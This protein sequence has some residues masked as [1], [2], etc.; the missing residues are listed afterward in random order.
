MANI[1]VIIPV[2]GCR[3]CLTE[4][5][6]RLTLV[7]SAIS[8]GYEIIFV[9]DGSE[10]N[11][12]EMIERLGKK[13]KSIKGIKL[14]RNFGQHQAISAGVDRAGGK[15]IV[16]MDCDLQDRPEEIKNLYNKA[17]R[18]KVDIVFA[19]RAVRH[20]S[21]GRMFGSWLYHTLFTAL[22]GIKSDPAVGNFSIVSS[23][24]ID[25]FRKF[26]ERHRSY[27]Q[28]VRQLGY[29][30]TTIN[31]IHDA[32]PVGPSSYTFG[33]LMTHAVDVA[34]G[35]STRMLTLWMFSGFAIA[36]ISGIIAVVILAGH[37][38]NRFT[39]AG[40]VS[41][42]VLTSFLSGMILSGLGVIAL[43]LGKIFEEVKRRPLYVIERKM[44]L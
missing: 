41:V 14:S 42:M 8:G 28:I 4:L 43:Y 18:E 44:N 40:W 25:A 6:R 23:R 35:F 38:M 33:K 20:D 39:V 31:V 11:A 30:Q 36:G 15:W 37:F 19:R 17:V 5:H 10:D 13:D 24:A 26:P 34:T 1:S 12:W 9:D 29:P 16:V 22:S 32:R 2:F 3:A 7:L 27:L 21:T